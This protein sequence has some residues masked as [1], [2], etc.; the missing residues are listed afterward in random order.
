MCLLQYEFVGLQCVEHIL[1]WMQTL[2]RAEIY[3]TETSSD[4]PRLSIHLN[5]RIVTFNIFAMRLYYN[6]CTTSKCDSKITIFV[7]FP[8]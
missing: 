1:I 8:Y 7:I 2:F 5:V 3:F 4:E 6:C